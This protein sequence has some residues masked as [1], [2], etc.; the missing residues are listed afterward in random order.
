MGS[1]L[2]QQLHKA[3]QRILSTSYNGSDVQF[4]FLH[5]QQPLTLERTPL[6]RN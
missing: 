6:Q 4:A 5:V 2:M 1:S 3:L